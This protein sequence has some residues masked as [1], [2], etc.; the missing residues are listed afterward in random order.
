MTAKLSQKSRNVMHWKLYRNWKCPMSTDDKKESSG[1]T[2]PH[3]FSLS[4]STCLPRERENKVCVCHCELNRRS[5]KLIKMM[6][7]SLSENSREISRR[8]DAKLIIFTAQITVVVHKQTCTSWPKNKMVVSFC[9]PATLIP[10]H[11]NY[12]RWMQTP[13]TEPNAHRCGLHKL[14]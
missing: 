5:E 11:T 1:S 13:L 4:T 7:T 14:T 9:R 12:H 2:F 8:K 10:P 3:N 6:K